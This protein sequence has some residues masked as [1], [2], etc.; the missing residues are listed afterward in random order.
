MTWI[1]TISIPNG[2]TVDI[3][4]QSLFPGGKGVWRSSP[5]M[6][7]FVSATNTPYPIQGWIQQFFIEFTSP[8]PPLPPYEADYWTSGVDSS[9]VSDM[10]SSGGTPPPTVASVE[11]T[12]QTD[13]NA[14]G[15]SDGDGL[16]DADESVIGTNPKAWDTDGDDIGDGSE[17]RG[18][19]DPLNID[20]DMDGEVDSQDQLPTIPND[21]EATIEALLHTATAH[22]FT[23]TPSVTP[24]AI[25]SSTPIAC[26]PTAPSRLSVGD[27]GRVIGEGR[28]GV[29]LRGNYGFDAPLIR[30]LDL[31]TEFEVIDLNAICVEGTNWYKIAIDG[32]EAGWIPETMWVIDDGAASNVY[33]IEPLD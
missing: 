11:V 30:L 21:P 7:Y 32:E 5:L 18:G 9:G 26:N 24:S 4:D 2:A 20:T 14:S 33:V 3:L 31:N 1:S 29:N 27:Q 13:S 17:I 12:A 19:T 6:Y 25:F 10:P 15:D 23:P 16:T 28:T 22:A 8:C